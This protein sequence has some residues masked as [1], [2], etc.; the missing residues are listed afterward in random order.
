MPGTDKRGYLAHGH[1]DALRLFARTPQVF[2][3]R[4]SADGAVWNS[5]PLRDGLCKLAHILRAQELG[6]RLMVW[7]FAVGELM[8]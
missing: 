3:V 1:Q 5:P 8:I 7:M 2:G 4:S 6:V